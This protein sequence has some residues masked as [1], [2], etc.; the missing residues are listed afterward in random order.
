MKIN[1]AYIAIK[2]DEPY[3]KKI[4]HF[5]GYEDRPTFHD[6]N[7]LQEELKNDPEFNKFFHFNIEEYEIIEA[8]VQIIE[9][10]NQ[11]IKNEILPEVF[12][13]RELKDK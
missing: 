5:C 12:I 7:H 4:Y 2:K 6:Y 11:I 8:P 10:F 3:P 1:Y 9:L 13:N